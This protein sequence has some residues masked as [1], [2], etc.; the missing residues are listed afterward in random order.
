[1]RM[2]REGRVGLVLTSMFALSLLN[3]AAPLNPTVKVAK[4]PKTA[5]PSEC[6]EGLA[7]QPV[8]STELT[9]IPEPPPST[10]PAV[11][12]PLRDLLRATQSEAAGRDRDRFNEAFARVKAYPSGSEKNAAADVIRV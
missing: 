8:P 10:P 5:V 2:L 3:A 11:S 7:P 4:H 6:E 12:A 9:E 1:M